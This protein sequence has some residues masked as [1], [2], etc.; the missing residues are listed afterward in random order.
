[1]L[2]LIILCKFTVGGITVKSKMF[3]AFIFTVAIVFLL[4][5]VMTA[6][7]DIDLDVTKESVV[8]I[9]A[10][11]GD[12]YGNWGSGFLIGKQGDPVQYIVTNYHVIEGAKSIYLYRGVDDLIELYT[13]SIQ[14]PITDIAVLELSEQLYNQKT[15]TLRDSEDVKVGDSV[16][17]LGFPSAADDMDGSLSGK[18]EDVTITS[19]IISKISE[20]PDNVPFYQMDAT[21]NYGNSGGPL[22]DENG[23]VIGVNTF[24]MLDNDLYAAVTLTDLIDALDS[25]GITYD[26]YTE[27]LDEPPTETDTTEDEIVAPVDE[28]ENDEEE[29]NE[30]DKATS[31]K[32][33]SKINTITIVIISAAVLLVIALVF[34][35]VLARRNKAKTHYNANNLNAVNM[36]RQ[37]VKKVTGLVTCVGGVFKGKNIEVISK[38]YFGRNDDCHV[39]YPSDTKGISGKHCALEFDGGSFYLTDLGS[40]YGTFLSNGQKLTPKMKY[41]IS[42][43]EQ[44]YLASSAELFQVNIIR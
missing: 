4:V 20:T 37:G 10:D 12:G 42:D 5:P 44:F 1:M 43:G 2:I 36:P 33:D 7:A 29:D 17:C 13:T 9:I 30:E 14:M 19:G 21:I 11:L 27:A 24:G 8:R 18:P 15:L 34:I 31:T 6:N 28:K 39:K 40:S 41:T 23:C 26:K 25:R 3:K 16:Y 35:F 32:D 38:I 22:V